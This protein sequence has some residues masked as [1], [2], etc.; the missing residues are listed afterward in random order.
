VDN[1]AYGFTAVDAVD[2]VD[3]VAADGLGGLYFDDYGADDVAADFADG[4]G[5]FD[6]DAAV[7]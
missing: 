4:V 7:F 5:G 3:F 1:A 2:A 6:A